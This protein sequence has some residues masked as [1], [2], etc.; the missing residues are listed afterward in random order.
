MDA[1]HVQERAIEEPAFG[2]EHGGPTRV[3]EAADLLRVRSGE[4][5]ARRQDHQH[6]DGA[7]VQGERVALQDR[8]VDAHRVEELAQRGGAT[9]C[10]VVDGCGPRRP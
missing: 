9:R 6:A 4:R 7:R 2:G 3:D 5:L 1:E 8:G 10:L